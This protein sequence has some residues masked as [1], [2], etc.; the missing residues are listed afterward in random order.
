MGIATEP[1][2]EL[3]HKIEVL[4]DLEEPVRELRE[5]HERKRELWFPSDLLA[6]EPESCSAVRR[7]AYPTRSGP[8]L[9]STC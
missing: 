9:L 8:R 3:A 7:T 2:P 5:N 4:K 1:E 6:P